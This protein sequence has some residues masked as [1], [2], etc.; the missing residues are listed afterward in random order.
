MAV[1][2]HHRSLL[3]A[4]MHRRVSGSPEPERAGVREFFSPLDEL[5]RVFLR[6][7]QEGRPVRLP[8]PDEEGPGLEVGELRVELAHPATSP[9]R[10]AHI[11]SSAVARARQGGEPWV[12]VVAGFAVPVLRRVLSRVPR[13]K[14]ERGE[15]E[16][17]MLAALTAAV[18]SL[19]PSAPQ[20]DRELF[21]AADRA[22][23]R[24]AYAATRRAHH[25]VH[26]LDDRPMD[27]ALLRASEG[28]DEYLVLWRAV[29][30]K[31]VTR[32]QAQ[33][34]A[35]TR[36]NGESMTALAHEWRVSRRQL[37]R[38]REQAE[39]RLAEHLAS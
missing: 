39:T 1:F 8:L 27:P 9:E 6:L 25:T 16:Q 31:V 23:H 3:E 19:N 15:V 18:R 24:A 7:G 10:R 35:L 2:V 17:E 37:Y 11:W 22:A 21:R 14:V 36:L 32:R 4:F 13:G 34:V 30:D 28:E 33:V 12:T 5:D 38:L 20:L 26:A 29:E